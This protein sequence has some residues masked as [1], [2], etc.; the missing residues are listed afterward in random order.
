MNTDVRTARCTSDNSKTC[1]TSANQCKDVAISRESGFA[2]SIK[3]F[4]TSTRKS[5][6]PG[7]Y[8][9]CVTLFGHKFAKHPQTAKERR[10]YLQFKL[11]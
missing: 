11:E 1:A 4:S 10:P 8:A 6:P 2:S 3:R 5:C 9:F 7:V